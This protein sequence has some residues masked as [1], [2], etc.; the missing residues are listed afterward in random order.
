MKSEANVVTLT[1]KEKSVSKITDLA[2]LTYVCHFKFLC[3]GH[4]ENFQQ[5][6]LKDCIKE[7]TNGRRLLD[8]NHE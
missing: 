2:L 4:T 7:M 3:A 8:D 6:S 5:A 1:E